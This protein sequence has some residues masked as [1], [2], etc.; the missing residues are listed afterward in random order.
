MKFRTCSA[1]IAIQ[2][3]LIGIAGPVLAKAGPASD[4]LATQHFFCKTGYALG[5]ICHSWDEGKANHVAG[6]LKQNRPLTCQSGL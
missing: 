5:A 2:T 3:L 4:R 6:I 1:S